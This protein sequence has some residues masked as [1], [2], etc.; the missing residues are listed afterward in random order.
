MDGS[1]PPPLS[2]W[3]IHGEWALHPLPKGIT[4]SWMGF[5]LMESGLSRP[6]P[7]DH[8][9]LGEGVTERGALQASPL[10]HPRDWEILFSWRGCSPSLSLGDIPSWREELSTPLPG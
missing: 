6:L 5:C 3:E 4:Q 2:V 1:L 10:G 7:L 8:P 9:G